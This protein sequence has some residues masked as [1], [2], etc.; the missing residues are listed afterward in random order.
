MKSLT[1]PVP[2]GLKRQSDQQVLVLIHISV[3]YRSQRYNGLLD[4]PG[5]KKRHP[6][7]PNAFLRRKYFN[8]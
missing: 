1:I 6:G 4:P 2:H 7:N 8:L 3:P 5:N